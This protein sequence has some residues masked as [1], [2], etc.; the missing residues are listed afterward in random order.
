MAV[1]NLKRSPAVK[2]RTASCSILPLLFCT[3]THFTSIMNTVMAEQSQSSNRSIYNGEEVL[4]MLF[5]DDGD[6]G[7]GEVIFPGSDDDFE[8]DEEENI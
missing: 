3:P 5:L 4:D 1:L 2:E 7:L 6:L 8:V